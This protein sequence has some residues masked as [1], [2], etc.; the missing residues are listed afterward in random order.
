MRPRA[1][2]LLCNKLQAHAAV[3]VGGDSLATGASVCH[4]IQGRD[5]GTIVNKRI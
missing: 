2:Y 3:G 1:D 5:D 4:V